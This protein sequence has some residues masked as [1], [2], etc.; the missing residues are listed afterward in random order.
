MIAPPSFAFD[1]LHNWPQ[2]HSDGIS[3]VCIDHDLWD[4]TVVPVKSASY[5]LK[6]HAF[7]HRQGR[8]DQV[9]LPCRVWT[10]ERCATIR[11]L[12]QLELLH[13]T[14]GDE[15]FAEETAVYVGMF[16]STRWSTIARAL[17][18]ASAKHAD[19]DSRWW[20]TLHRHDDDL[21]YIVTNIEPPS[22]RPARHLSP[23]AIADAWEWS[24]SEALALPGL[25]SSPRWHGR[26]LPDRS[27]DFKSFGD[28]LSPDELQRAITFYEQRKQQQF[29]DRTLSPAEVT[30][31]GSAVVAE[32]IAERSVRD[33]GD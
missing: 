18:R 6:R 7:G 26:T 17:R 31:L 16:P 11:V 33:W 1:D 14:L 10:C 12:R 5:C 28:R 29:G 32:V 9:Q 20:M 3:L 4:A 8:T 23:I 22:G 2:S 30:L 24:R 25:S 19:P 15:S 21:R 13:E 27:S